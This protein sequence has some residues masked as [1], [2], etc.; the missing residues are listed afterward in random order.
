MNNSNNIFFESVPLGVIV[1]ASTG[2]IT[3]ANKHIESMLNLEVG[4]IVG[5]EWRSLG[6]KFISQDG[7]EWDLEKHPIIKAVK[8]KQDVKDEVVGIVH[9]S[10]ER[11]L[12]VNIS[13]VVESNSICNSEEEF[14]AVMYLTDIT[15]VA[16][17]EITCDEVIESI[18]L[19]T[20]SW[21]IKTGAA[22][23]SNQWAKML[24]YT[25]DELSPINIDVWRRLAHPDDLKKYQN[26]LQ[27]HFN[28]DSN[29]CELAMRM[30]HKDGHWVWVRDIGKVTQWSEN[31]VPLYMTGIHQ[32]ISDYKEKELM[33]SRRVEYEKILS[34]ISTKF[35]RSHDIDN[36]ILE[37]FEQLAALN[38]ASRVYL[39]M[40]NND[41]DTISNTHE[42]CAEGV[43]AQKQFLQNLPINIFQWSG[44]K[45]YNN[46]ILNISDV[47][48]LGPEA[49]AEKEIYEYQG[50]QSLLILP[51]FVKNSLLGFVGFDNVSS[52]DSWSPDDVDLLSTTASV[53]SY[54]LERQSAEQELKKNYENL[55]TYF[56][57][58]SDFVTILNEQGE[59][60]EVNEQVI[61]KLG[62]TNEDIIGKHVLMLHPPEVHDEATKIIRDMIAGNTISC[63][64]PILT[65]EGEQMLVETTVTKG[66]WD[67]NDALFAIS[68]DISEKT[69]SAKKFEQIFDNIP[70]MA[71]ITDLSTGKYIEV[72]K[73]FIEKLGFTFEEAVGHSPVDLFRV[74]RKEFK[75]LVEEVSEYGFVR[76]KELDLCHKDGTIINTLLSATRISLLDKKYALI[77]ATDVSENKQYEQKLFEAMTRAKE[78]DTL[79]SAFLATMNH[80][81]RTPLNHIIGF[82]SM[83][84]DM[85]EDASIKEFSELIHKSGLNLLS[86][87]E[88]VFDLAM[89]DQCKINLREEE[90]YIRDVYLDLKKVLQETVSDSD[91]SNPIRLEFKIDSRTVTQ[92]IITDKSKI[93]QVVSNLIK[94]AVK[95]THRGVIALEIVMEKANN[96]SIIVKDTGIGIPEEKQD[97]IFEFFRQVDDSHTREYEGIGIGLAISQKIADAMGGEIS[98]KSVAGEGSE[99]KFSFP[100]KIY[101]EEFVDEQNIPNKLGVPDFSKKKIL[102][103]EDDPIGME[104]IDNVLQ[105]TSC[106]VVKATNGIEALRMIFEHTTVD[107]VLMDLKMPVMDGF[108]ATMQIRQQMP[109]LPIIALTAYS[110]QKDR[111][112]A[113]QAGCN[114]ILTKPVNRDMLFKKMEDF[115]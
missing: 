53:F 4:E 20:W 56:D 48:K 36:T 2:V 96:L 7:V 71:A 14:Q 74:A 12:W 89:M 25:L 35:I 16:Q 1:Y 46:E 47:S 5:K 111:E 50:I 114:D 45:L 75:I 103:V 91:K 27:K 92:K 79:K 49:R 9:P 68:K 83:L 107:L 81:L 44:E 31:R 42:W 87:I 8:A 23:Y 66:L 101:S 22:V 67:G 100:I 37:S 90:V 93:M 113:L 106:D 39:F 10:I 110:M 59:I 86:I 32:D 62:Y 3:Y 24:G 95:F 21:N 97:I 104:M 19:G 11:I 13:V 76:N 72:N 102:I 109:F 98:L 18:K 115:I 40:I 70:V 108:E 30:L 54:A 78:S 73:V 26:H 52:S 43:S 15:K 58:N 105:A 6:Y 57:L 77:L 65:K 80:E 88:D 60:V 69:F 28:G 94:N 55:R 61:Q 85:T 34:D 51:V 99:F 41:D 84:P 17:S 64:L 38:K 82:S 63:P 112:K 29:K 33:L